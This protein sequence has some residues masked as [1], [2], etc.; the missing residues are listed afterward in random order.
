MKKSLIVASFLALSLAAQAAVTSVAGPGGATFLVSDNTLNGTADPSYSEPGA[1]GGQDTTAA[2]D[3]WNNDRRWGNDGSATIASWSFT[4]LATGT[5]DVY[6]SWRNGPQG[7][8]SIAHYTG[9]DGLAATDLDQRVGAGALP[10]VLLNDGVRDINFA[11]VGSV[12]IADGTFVATV[13]DSVTG[14]AD[15][16]TFIFADALALTQVPEPSGL[17]LIGLGAIALVRRRR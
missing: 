16:T 13:D 10:G 14:S 11:L 7:N 15:G 4:G 17:A 12:A 5:Y 1:F 6:A 8:V 3:S 9:T 2:T